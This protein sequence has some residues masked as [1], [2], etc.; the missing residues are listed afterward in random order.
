MHAQPAL[1]MHKLLWCLVIGLSSPSSAQGVSRA[2]FRLFPDA[3]EIA[4][5]RSAAP[6]S[7]SAQA[8]VY[9]L[10]PGGPVKAVT[11]TNGAACMVSRDHRES[12][13]PICFDAEAAHVVLPSELEQLRLREV[14]A[15]E[16]V[17]AKR[18]RDIL[19]QRGSRAGM[20][21]G[22][23]YMMSRHQVIYASAQGRRVGQWFPH[24][25][26]YSPFATRSGLTAPTLA[27]G[28]LT[29]SD[30]GL[31]SAHFVVMVREFAEAPPLPALGPTLTA[32]PSFL[33]T[34][35]EYQLRWN[36][37]GGANA[38][39]TTAALATTYPLDTMVLRRAL[40]DFVVKA[41]SARGDSLAGMRIELHPEKLEHELK[42]AST[43][44][45]GRL[46]TTSFALDPSTTS[47][48]VLPIAVK[49]RGDRPVTVVHRGMS[50]RLLPGESTTAFNGVE[51]S[52][53]WGVIVDT[54][55]L[56]PFCP[57]T[58][59]TPR[60]STSASVDVLIVT[61]CDG[62]RPK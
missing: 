42:R 23:A 4:L 54:G 44:C 17:I 26:I 20:R 35:D 38:V 10:R 34:G 24:V 21:A 28:D 8:D 27:N 39:E 41:V 3:Y 25:M 30:E 14:G 29:L 47:P 36:G 9:V 1:S 51:F 16:D 15:T 13:Y 57:L 56:N 52:G 40:G 61:Q 6:A 22:I 62:L 43:T 55:P 50:V 18:G 60:P 33:C 49:N 59:T 37:E 45:A 7:L 5:A 32:T 31:V 12:L 58:A 11:G 2:G 19:K 53:D 48:R 46:S